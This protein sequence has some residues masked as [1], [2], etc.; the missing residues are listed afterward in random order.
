MLITAQRA[1]ETV[2]KLRTNLSIWPTMRVVQAPNLR[3]GCPARSEQFARPIGPETLLL[4]RVCRK[5]IQPR[6][7]SPIEHKLASL[8]LHS[9]IIKRDKRGFSAVRVEVIR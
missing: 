7:L 2:T 6:A 3:F 5:L 1:K 9:Q 8:A 4:G